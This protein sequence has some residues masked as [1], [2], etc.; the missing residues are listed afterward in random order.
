MKSGGEELASVYVIRL[1]TL[2][3][4]MAELNE[5][6][7]ERCK[8]VKYTTRFLQAVEKI[9]KYTTINQSRHRDDVSSCNQYNVKVEQKA[10]VDCGGQVLV[11]VWG[12]QRRQRHDDQRHLMFNTEK[13]KKKLFGGAVLI[14]RAAHQT[15][16]LVWW[17]LVDQIEPV[18]CLCVVSLFIVVYSL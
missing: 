17:S 6:T 7:I 5:R 11:L 4:W 10:T 9:R 16:P 3:V 14:G 18:W 13:R 2:A 15:E 8:S 1:Q 12:L